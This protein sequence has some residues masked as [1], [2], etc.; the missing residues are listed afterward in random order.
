MIASSQSFS[1]IQRRMLDGPPPALPE[2]SGEPLNTTAILDPSP[3]FLGSSGLACILEIICCRNSS[4]PSSMSGVPAPKRPLKPRVLCS[5]STTFF[6]SF[7]STPK[8]GFAIM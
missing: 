8:G 7:Q 4:D 2:K 1:M 6:W 3:G 5:F